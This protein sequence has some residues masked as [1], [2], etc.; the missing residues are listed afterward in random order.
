MERSA[1][2][3]EPDYSISQNYFKSMIA[4]CKSISHGMAAAEYDEQKH[5]NGKHVAI[6]ID[7]HGVY[8]I[9]GKEVIKEMQEHQAQST[10]RLKNNYFRIE[11]V[12]SKEEGAKE[13]TEEHWKKVISDYSSLM[14][15][16]DTQ[17]FWI[18]H[19]CTEHDELPHV[20]G[21]VNRID[22]NG[23][24]LSD[25]FSQMRSIEVI[26][27]MTKERGYRTAEELS[28]DLRITIREKAHEALKLLKKYNFDD[29][30]AACARVGLNIRP[31]ISPNG[32]RN[33]YYISMGEKE[34]KAS[35]IDRALTDSRINETH[36][37]ERI[38]YERQE[39][40]KQWQN[41]TG[42]GGYGL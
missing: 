39:R 25:Q 24:V 7:R 28:K 32:K 22:R 10:H 41:T 20:H 3:T 31:N 26:N 33:G 4:N 2:G 27:R 36:K 6:E 40:Q 35:Q 14:G 19:R 15:I 38:A 29:F 34:Y 18:L 30:S 16:S 12:P 1:D 9:D 13:W 21:V 42:R 8:G 11:I 5:V 37:K 17:S 23:N